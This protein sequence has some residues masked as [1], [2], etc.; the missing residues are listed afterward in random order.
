MADLPLPNVF[1]R[2]A[3]TSHL[4]GIGLSV[5]GFGCFSMMD[6][7]VKQLSGRY[8]V[9]QILFF[10]AL[11]AIIPILILATRSSEG[12]ATLK[13]CRLKWHVARGSCGVCAGFLGFYAIGR[14][15]LADFYALVFSAPLFITAISSLILGEHVGWR[16]WV[17]VI[18]GFCGVIIMLRPGDGVVS[19]A[20][21]AAVIAA[22]LFATGMMIV[23]WM[24]NTE[25]SLSF[26]LYGN[27]ANLCVTTFIMP[28]AFV[29]PSWRDLG[30]SALCGGF[31]FCALI[32]VITAF[33]IA[34]AA[35]V[36]PFQYSQ[37]LWGVLI[38]V[39]IFGEQPDAWLAVGGGII[40]GSGLFILHRE[41]QIAKAAKREQQNAS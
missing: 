27:L 23:R 2:S 21:W 28:S 4:R 18:I 25:S 7:I 22:F 14:L 24:R 30:L 38:G 26:A 29:T 32:S 41:T 8:S 39:L 10:N 35:T 9:P 16:R 33:R 17:A 5:L 3:P 11:F 15:P 34:P 20:S 37:M 13:T 19:T 12:L 1:P 36:A 40:I 6:A 31:G